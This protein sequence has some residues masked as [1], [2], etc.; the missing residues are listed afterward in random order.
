MRILA[1][2]PGINTTGLAWRC[3]GRDIRVTDADLSAIST[4]RDKAREVAR[5]VPDVCFDHVYI[6]LPQVYPYPQMKGDPNDLVNLAVLI[7]GI[8][9]LVSHY[10][11][12]LIQPRKWK[13]QLPK[14]IHHER[15]LKQCPQFANRDLSLD[16]LDA[17]GLL[18]YGERE[19]EYHKRMRSL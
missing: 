15:I 8:V 2:D 13:G 1:V 14:K 10:K 4:Y 3:E 12:T 5:S 11:A 18:L 6:E 19:Q 16:A 9:S 17:L 7:G